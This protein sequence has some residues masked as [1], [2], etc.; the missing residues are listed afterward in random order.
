MSTE[1]R[2]REIRERAEAASPGPWRT[3]FIR[4]RSGD[5]AGDEH[6]VLTPDCDVV[7]DIAWQI[8]WDEQ[9]HRN[10]AFVAHARADVPWLLEQVAEARAEVTIHSLFDQVEAA[11]A[12]SMFVLGRD[13]KDVPVWVAIVARCAD[14]WK[15]VAAAEALTVE[16]EAAHQELLEA[17]RSTLERA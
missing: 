5:P 14:T 15:F 8:G 2:L 3:S 1:Q 7:A 10:A 4:S 11:G 6:S 9:Q 13:D 17:I 12:G 16:D